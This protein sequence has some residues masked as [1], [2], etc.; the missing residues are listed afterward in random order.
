ML[1]LV[2]QSI[3]EG[4]RPFRILALDGGGVRGLSGLVILKEYMDK[5]LIQE[6]GVVDSNK[7]IHCGDNFGLTGE[8]RTSFLIALMLGRLHIGQITVDILS[9]IAS[10]H[11]KSEIHRDLKPQNGDHTPSYTKL[12]DF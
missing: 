2:H 4:L 8:S 7:P 3:S 11:S 10:L 5:F 9:N 1:S 6:E 12:I